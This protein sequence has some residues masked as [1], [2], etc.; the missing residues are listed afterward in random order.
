MKIAFAGRAGLGGFLMRGESVAKVLGADII[1]LPTQR[2]SKHYDVIVLVKY[3]VGCETLLR[4]ACDRFIFDGLDGWSDKPNATP[5][6]L[7]RWRYKHLK[8]DDILATSPAC[9]ETMATSVPE[10][11]C[12]LLPHHADAKIDSSW[13]DPQGPVVYAG[14]QHYAARYLGDIERACRHVGRKFVGNFGRRPVDSLRGAALQLHPRFPPTDTPLNRLCKPQIKIA[15]AAAAGCPILATAH[16]CVTSLD[17][18][19]CLIDH[20]DNWERLLMRALESSPPVLQ[21]TLQEHAQK[22][23]KLLG[24]D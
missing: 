21:S 4:N 15:N 19:G 13:Y 9:L 24:C 7:W 17:S 2:I 20:H 6:D 10:A 22:L 1:P 3:A 23:R 11:R 16:P 18:G 12:H 5:E 8:F 14:G